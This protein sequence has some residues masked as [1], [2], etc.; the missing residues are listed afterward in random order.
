MK[1]ELYI[2]RRGFNYSQDGPG[3]R[4]IYHLKGCNLFCPWCSNP[5][6]MLREKEDKP[7]PVSDLV[8]EALSCVPMF[9]DGGGVTLTGGEVSMQADGVQN[10]LQNL[11]S[12]KIH[13]AIESNASLSGFREIIPYADYIMVDFK[14]ADSKCSKEMIGIDA[15]TVL[16][17]LKFALKEGH[18]LHIRI[19]LIHNFNDRKE[20]RE[21]IADVLSSLDGNFDVEILPY[22]EYGKEKWEKSGRKYTV[23]DGFVLPETVA[24]F[25]NELTNAGI[26]VIKT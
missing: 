24:D 10:L 17:N 20:Q 3:N 6:G 4:L 26:T 15:E 5:D 13:T 2:F 25:I 12:A 14:S 19:P 23:T 9:F 16:E 22:H 8:N 7:T 1:D 21:K 11:Q 18:T